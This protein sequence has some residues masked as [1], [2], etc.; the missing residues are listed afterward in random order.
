V[1]VVKHSA[2]PRRLDDARIVIDADAG[3]VSIHTSYAGVGDDPA[4]VEY[5]IRVPR[6]ATL[7]QVRLV[8]GGLSIS[9]VAGSVRAS[10]VNGG[11]Y[12]EQL[13]GQASLSS[14]NGR[15]EAGFERLSRGSPISLES[16]NGGIVLWLPAGAGA[17]LSASNLSGGI[18]ADFAQA[19]HAADGHRLDASVNGGGAAIR[20][21]NV[22]GGISI[23]ATSLR[24]ERP[25]S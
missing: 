23:R 9:G 24:R 20:L 11:I 12:A 17:T 3:Q 21:H 5:H 8:N 10:S 4:S 22:N 14:I 15:V 13:S 2:D 6:R 25:V 1:E 19:R 18:R 16:V 7:D